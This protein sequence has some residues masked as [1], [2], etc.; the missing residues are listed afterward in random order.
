MSRLLLL[1]LLLSAC[2]GATAQE[3]PTELGALLLK[4][5]AIRRAVDAVRASEPQTL[6]DQVRLCEVEAPPFKEARRAKLFA[7]MFRQLQLRNVRIDAEGNVLGERPGRSPRPAV[8]FTAHL[9]TV[10]PE[11]TNVTVRRDALNQANIQTP[12]TIIFAG[13]VG[14]EG[15]GDLRGVRRLFNDT[16]KGAVDRF[17][18]IDG[19]GLGITN[20]GVGSVRFRVTFSGPGGHSFGAFGTVNPAHALGRA[21]ARIADFRVPSGP[22]TT[23]NV[24]R[25]GGGTSVNAIPEEAWME[26]D[27]RSVDSGPLYALETELR[28]VVQQAADEENTRWGSRQIKVTVEA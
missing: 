20:L 1:L 18:S 3:R 27:L 19:T 21:L 22:R 14:E 13:T 25:I 9:D 24:G 17:V 7:E 6:A 8:L 12:G 11:G 26:V 15:L 5:E 4:N 23:F 10:F 28:R 2:S 16:L